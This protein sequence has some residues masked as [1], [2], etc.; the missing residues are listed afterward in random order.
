MTR[1]DAYR[2]VQRN[3]M[4]TWESRRPFLDVLREDPDVVGA[5]GDE[6]LAAC[7]DLSG[8][9]ANVDRIFAALDDLAPL[10][11]PTGTDRR[12]REQALASPPLQRQGARALRG[13][14]RPHAR[15]GVRPRLG[16]RRRAP[17]PHPRQGAGPHRAV[18]VLV[19][20]DRAPRA[21]NH[22]V[23]SDP[24]DFPETA[25]PDIA[26]RAMLVQAARPVRLE[27]VARGYLFGAAWSDYQETGTVRGPP[28]PGRAPP[29]RAAPGAD[30]HAH[31]QGRRA[32]TTSRSPTPTPPSWSA[33]TASRS[34]A[35]SRSPIYRFGAELARAERGLILAD[36]KLEFGDGRRPTRRDRRDDDARLVALLERRRPRRRDVAAVV[37]Q[38]VRARPLPLDR[39]EHGAA[40]AAHA[41]VGDRGHAGALRGGLRAGERHSF[42]TWYGDDE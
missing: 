8:A 6:R 25:G 14:P 7:F 21:R 18:D 20:A 3:A 11:G 24:T 12:C 17:R 37:R 30:L 31:H 23:S 28:A 33:P 5:L 29:G 15:R 35:T 39:V 2:A 13:R 34:S 27:C 19:R 40:G 38:A 10:P 41:G 1:D 22:L 4:T 26:G 32:A 36:T 16:V 42:D 9:L